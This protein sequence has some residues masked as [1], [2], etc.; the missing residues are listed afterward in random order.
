MRL[1]ICLRNI[2]VMWM[3]NIWKRNSTKRKNHTAGF[4]LSTIDPE[5][6]S[7]F[8][9]VHLLKE[10]LSSLSETPDVGKGQEGVAISVKMSR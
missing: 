8:V 3:L 2:L 6:I 4:T 9:T 1:K 5:Q 7:L 10:V